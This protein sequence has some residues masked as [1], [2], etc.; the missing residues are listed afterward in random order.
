MKLLLGLLVG[1]VLAVGFFLTVV[2]SVATHPE[3]VIGMLI[4]GSAVAPVTQP[5]APLAVGRIPADQAPLIQAAAVA[6]TCH[7]LPED[8]AAIA[9]TES[10][11][12]RN[13]G[14]HTPH[15]G[16]IVGYGQFDP[17]TWA[18]YGL[19][20]IYN[21]ADA[22]PAIARALCGKGYGANR[23][24][25]LDNFGGCLNPDCLG[26]GKGTYAALIERLAA[27][28]RPANDV[29]ALA[30]TWITEPPLR[31]VFG[32]T[33]RSGVDCSGLTQAVYAAVGV[34]LDRTALM[35]YD[36]RSIVT[37]E[38]AEQ[39]Q[40]GD[41]LFFSNTYMPGVSHVAIYV[42]DGLMINAADERT[43]VVVA[44]AFTGYWG[45]HFSAAGR[46]RR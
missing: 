5:S 3:L 21:P 9:Q 7:V 35:Q 33:D 14:M 39:A 46:V 44:P 23:E 15:N 17:A 29:V 38:T 28:F 16:G 31:Y 36:Q 20:D 24:R 6:S 19:G 8:L 42:G 13:P 12:G 30:R 34:H 18:A 4:Q 37:L 26:P 11:F 32:G 41:L 40:P 45:S 10:D 22:L 1:L 43:G 27:T 25:G 2:A